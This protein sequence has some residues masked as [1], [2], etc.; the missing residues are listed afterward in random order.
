M[1]SLYNPPACGVFY[2]LCWWFAGFLH[3]PSTLGCTWFSSNKK[4]K[5]IVE[6]DS[7]VVVLGAPDAGCYSAEEGEWNERSWDIDR[8]LAVKDKQ[9]GTRT[10]KVNNNF[11]YT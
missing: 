9:N 7:D 2:P 1:R 5:E 8:M 11:R 6:W 4:K 10:H 3:Y